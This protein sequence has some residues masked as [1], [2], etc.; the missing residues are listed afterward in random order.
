M[1]VL[2]IQMKMQNNKVI[3]KFY[4]KPISSKKVILANSALPSS[5]KRA[6]LTEG[7]I[8]RLRYTDR[9]LPWS[10]ITEILSE[11]SNEMRLSGYNHKFRAEIISAALKGFRKQALT[12]D[13]GGKPLFRS[14]GYERESRR[15]NK[16]ISREAWFRKTSDVVGFV[17]VSPNGELASGLQKIVTEEA[18]KIGMKV[19]V[20]E[21]SGTSLSSLLTT[22]NLSG[23]LFPACDIEEQGASHSRRGANYSG[24]CKLCGKVYIGETGFGAH[25]RVSQHQADIRVNSIT[26]SLAMH[27]VEEH[28][29][30]QRNPAAFSF[31]V[32]R[33]GPKALERG[34]G[35]MPNC[36]CQSRQW[37]L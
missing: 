21:Q 36:Q 2:D 12:S 30:Q 35:G 1:P 37:T 6:S 3:Y 4:K 23:C 18:E 31:S 10:M 26:N 7:A 15:R 22:P 28:P 25:S 32:S 16:L 13:S 27:L 17:P 33:T 19:R 14:R 11:Y 29:Q 24:T 9:S 5:I 8:R 20:T 34:P